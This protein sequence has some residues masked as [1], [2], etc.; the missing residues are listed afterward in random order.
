MRLSNN[1][2]VNDPAAVLYSRCTIDLSSREVRHRGSCLPE[3]GRGGWRDSA[4]RFRFWANARSAMRTRP[5]NPLIINTGILTGSSVM[6]GLR[7]YFSAY[8]PLKT[9][10]QG[11]AR[12]D[13]VGGKR[14]VRGQAEMDGTR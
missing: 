11:A 14:Q 6:T 2:S 4:A 5:E 1:E 8:S 13:V 7:S 9:I 10:Q 12:R 3:S